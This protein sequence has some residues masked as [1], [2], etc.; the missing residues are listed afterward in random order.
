SPESGPVQIFQMAVSLDQ[1]PAAA[2][3]K[4]AEWRVPWSRADDPGT[5]ADETLNYTFYMK[6]ISDG[7]NG[8]LVI[9]GQ[10]GD[11]PTPATGIG[12]TTA[13]EVK[14]IMLTFVYNRSGAPQED[15]HLGTIPPG[16]HFYGSSVSSGLSF[17]TEPGG[18]TGWPSFEVHDGVVYVDDVYWEGG[19]NL[20]HEPSLAARN[21]KAV[22]VPVLLNH[23]DLE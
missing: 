3:E 17:A 15:P 19:L 4:F 8:V 23:F 12:R 22:D 20:D 11:N 14:W 18:G 13:N 10:E 16:A 2:G 1:V 21:L 7:A 5:P 9:A 6:F